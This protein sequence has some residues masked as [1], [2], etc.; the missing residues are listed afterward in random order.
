MTEKLWLDLS[1]QYYTILS[2]SYK[3]MQNPISRTRARDH[4][5]RLEDHVIELDAGRETG[6]SIA[7]ELFLNL[8]IP[9]TTMIRYY[10]HSGNS[11]SEMKRLIGANRGTFYASRTFLNQNHDTVFR[12]ISKDKP[13]VFVFEE[14]GLSKQDIVKQINK[15]TYGAYELNRKYTVL[16]VIIK[17][18]M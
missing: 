9:E 2:R 5:Y 14:C 17:I 8:V 18:G 1:T 4:G 13:V 3:W 10:G 6:K 7:L 11:A 16:P 12:G 15:L